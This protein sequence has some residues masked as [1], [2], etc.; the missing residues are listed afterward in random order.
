MADLLTVRAD[1]VRSG[2]RVHWWEY[3]QGHGTVHYRVGVPAKVCSV[4]P[5]DGG[6]VRYVLDRGPAQLMADW[7][8]AVERPHRSEGVM[9]SDEAADFYEDD[10]PTEKI[11]EAF[12]RGP[13]GVTMRPES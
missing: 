7:T 3:R 4:E 10:E 1:E 8:V 11:V 6:L 9:T 5:P 13:H 12:N 2:D